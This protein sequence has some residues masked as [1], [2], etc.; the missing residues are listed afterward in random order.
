MYHWARLVEA[1]YAAERL[2]ELAE[3]PELTSPDIRNRNL[4]LKKEGW[5]VVEAPR[6]TLFHHYESDDQGLITGANLIVATQ[7]N[8]GRINLSVDKAARMLIKNGEVND[9]LLNMVEMAFRA[10]DPCMACATHALPG[11][12]PLEVNIYDSSRDLQRSLRQG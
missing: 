3:H 4:N 7:N 6:G 5:G 8:M 2:L 12:L 11:P 1:L 9:G 10:Y